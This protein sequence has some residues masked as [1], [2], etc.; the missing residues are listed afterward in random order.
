MPCLPK[1]TPSVAPGRRSGEALLVADQ[2]V[3]AG[4]KILDL[5]QHMIKTPTCRSWNI[6]VE[7]AT[8]ISSDSLA[9]SNSERLA[10]AALALPPRE[11]TQWGTMWRVFGADTKAGSSPSAEQTS[12]TL[13]IYRNY[14]LQ[15]RE[16]TAPDFSYCQQ[17][18][19]LL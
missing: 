2:C 13:P 18:K 7:P 16:Y 8:T 15:Y 1:L 11:V 14:Q 5:I 6:F 12:F 10:P 4:P 17:S 3:S 19:S 9:L